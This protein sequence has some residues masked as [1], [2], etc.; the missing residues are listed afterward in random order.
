M[1]DSLDPL[2]QSYVLERNKVV[3]AVS[4]C[5]SIVKVKSRIRL[6]MISDY[7]K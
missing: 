4:S 6:R 1:M 5:T 2:K 3:G 7:A